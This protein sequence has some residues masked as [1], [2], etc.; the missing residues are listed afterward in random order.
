MSAPI[1]PGDVVVCINAANIDGCSIAA[2]ALREGRNY[3]VRK[4][5]P[6]DADGD[7]GTHIYGVPARTAFGFRH[8]R[9]RKI[10][11]ADDI[12]TQFIRACKPV[13]IGVEA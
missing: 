8:V 13:K 10:D 3:R 9:F 12:F 11:A 1:E 2:R 6:P 7:C 4:V 5:L